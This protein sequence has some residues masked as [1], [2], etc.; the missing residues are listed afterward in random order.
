MPPIGYLWQVKNWRRV[1]AMLF[2]LLI[3][4]CGIG[5]AGRTLHTPKVEQFSKGA[6]FSAA[7][8][9]MFSHIPQNENNYFKP[10]DLPGSSPNLLYGGDFGVLKALNQL[11]YAKDK[12]YAVESIN[13]LVRHRKANL[14]FPFHSFW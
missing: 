6:Y 2:L 7:K 10:N 14:I 9:T 5:V 12:Q 11:F 1:T 4:C 3:Y 13:L 8:T